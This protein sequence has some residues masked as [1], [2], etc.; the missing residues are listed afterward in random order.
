MSVSLIRLIVEVTI[1]TSL[2]ILIIALTRKPIRRIAGARVSYW[3]WLLVPVSALVLALP[4]PSGSSEIAVQIFP[5]S[6]LGALPATIF[7]GDVADAAPDH[8]TIGLVVWASGSLLMLASMVR[9]QRAFIRSLGNLDSVQDGTHR[10]VSVDGPVLIGIWRPRIV[11]PTEFESLYSLE[12]RTLILAH[13]QAHRRSGDV[14]VNAIATIWLC[15]SWFNPLMYWAISRFRFD[16]ELACDAVVLGESGAGRR[17][18]A[19]TLLK[20]QLAADSA[21]RKPIGCHW[22]SNHPLKERIAVLK[23]TSPNFLRRLSGAALTSALIISGS[24]AA[25]ATQPRTAHAAALQEQGQRI[26]FSADRMSTLAN[27]DIDYSGNVVVK[28]VDGD[29]LAMTWSADAVNRSD[30]GSTLLTGAVRF[31]FA[32]YVLRTDRAT[33]AKDGTITMEAANL[34]RTS[35]AH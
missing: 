29:D 17:R 2:S 22:Q 25:W 32:G 34:S 23:R 24:Y 14:L 7:S 35:E 16:Q 6:A 27:G 12:E 26:T 13:E 5:H 3:L 21:W 8:A 9:R 15:L 31:S 33:L 18:Y 20:T 30:D 1:A 28:S 4:A 19:D 11:L 10:S